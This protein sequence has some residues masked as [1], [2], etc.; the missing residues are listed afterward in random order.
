MLLDLKKAEDH[1]Q[2]HIRKL[3]R[4]AK[5]EGLHLDCYG[6]GILSS[7]LHLNNLRNG[8]LHF[9]QE[10]ECLLLFR[11]E[12][13]VA[14][15]LLHLDLEKEIDQF[16]VLELMIRKLETAPLIEGL[17][18]FP[19]CHLPSPPPPLDEKLLTL[20][21]KEWLDHFKSRYLIDVPKKMLYDGLMKK[22]LMYQCH[23]GEE[24]NFNIT[25][26][27]FF[28]HEVKQRGPEH[29]IHLH[30][31]GQTLREMYLDPVR[32]ICNRLWD[33]T[34][35]NDSDLEG[36]VP[37][38][39]SDVVINRCYTALE[40]HRGDNP[41]QDWSWARPLQDDDGFSSPLLRM[42]LPHDHPML[43]EWVMDHFNTRIL[44]PGQMK[45]TQD[46]FLKG[47]IP[48]DKLLYLQDAHV[49][50]ESNS[51]S[52]I[53]T[54]SSVMIHKGR[55]ALTLMNKP[56]RFTLNPEDISGGISSQKMS[57]HSYANLPPVWL[58]SYIIMEGVDI[59]SV[60]VS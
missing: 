10:H 9:R 43:S 4:S 37:L 44:P 35:G 56:I 23:L 31:S 16:K 11:N 58:P 7:E 49:E 51:L 54:A 33:S 32:V 5:K 24:T 1:F 6:R 52:F 14:Q 55:K 46:D 34:P 48:S 22:G 21:M 40:T 59:Q 18:Q 50:F 2:Y 28:D 42:D 39:L 53:T 29:V 13:Q 45:L 15:H 57:F 38:L 47:N 3:I 17:D 27:S 12:E 60:D 41:D 25:R 26:M 30:R 36:P 8:P 19:Q 20:N